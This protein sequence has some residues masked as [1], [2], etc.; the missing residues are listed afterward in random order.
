MNRNSYRLEQIE[1]QLLDWLLVSDRDRSTSGSFVSDMAMGS[2]PSIDEQQGPSADLTPDW[3]PLLDE[4][5]DVQLSE[6]FVSAAGVRNILPR[7]SGH[8]FSQLG[9]RSVIQDRYYML[10]KQRLQ[11]DMAAQPPLFPW[12]TEFVEYHDVAEVGQALRPS[13]EAVWEWQLRGIRLPVMLPDSVMRDLFGQCRALVG[14]VVQDGLRLVQ[15]VESLFPG[16][17]RLLNGMAGEVLLGYSRDGEGLA[18]RLLGDRV[19]ESYETAA[20][21]QQML[22]TMIAAYEILKGLTM[23]LSAREPMVNRCWETAVGPVQVTAEYRQTA[24]QGMGKLQVD[25][26]LPT[27][28]Q[29]VLEGAGVTTMAQR[30]VGGV[31]TLL[32]A[33]V[34]PGQ[35]YQ[36]NL[37]LVGS[38]E[39][40]TFQVA[41]Q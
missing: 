34:Q 8:E 15:V 9:V 36:L 5:F 21:Q 2:A 17:G 1:Q 4:D 18:E 27:A 22:L 24:V 33:Q 39:P 7:S 6:T 11:A 13:L 32:V 40:L 3:D 19:P 20:P 30:S 16:Q 28:G 14:S 12:E 35:L 25:V 41:L 37:E 10:L 31:A 29:L 23:K 38:E 26:T